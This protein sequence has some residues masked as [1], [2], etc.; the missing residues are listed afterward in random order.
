[1]E[2]FLAQRDKGIIVLCRTSNPGAGEFQDLSVEGKPFYQYVARK[3][4]TDWNNNDNCLLVVGAT[5]SKEIAEV[6]KITGP[7]MVFLIPGIG[8]QGG[9]IEKTVKAGGAN[10]I[11][12]SSRA[13]L[14]ASGEEDFADAARKAALECKEEINKYRS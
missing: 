7:D 12:N 2:P 4:A 14:Y 1:L 3:V 10:I 9:D 13:I 8:A 11:I 5:Y 6:R